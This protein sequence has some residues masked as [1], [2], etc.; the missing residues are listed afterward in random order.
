MACDSTCVS[1]VLFSLPIHN[2]VRLRLLCS[3]LSL[4]R[5]WSGTVLV[6]FILLRVLSV[7]GT[8]YTVVQSGVGR[9]CID[10]SSVRMNMTLWRMNDKAGLKSIP[11][12]FYLGSP[13][14]MFMSPF[15]CEILQ[16]VELLLLLV[17]VRPFR[18]WPVWERFRT[19]PLRP[20]YS[21]SIWWVR[22]KVSVCENRATR[23]CVHCLVHV[24]LVHACGCLWF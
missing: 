16:T 13:W 23:V 4:A 15:F 12:A 24:Q 17:T 5:A 18:S 11:S 6:H 19:R 20:G 3:S 1:L 8:T 21:S 14:D 2:Y 10:D 9:S 7:L 22:I